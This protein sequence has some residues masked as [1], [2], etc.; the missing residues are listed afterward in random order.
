FNYGTAQGHW[1]EPVDGVRLLS[2]RF[3]PDLPEDFEQMRTQYTHMI[4]C[5]LAY[6][7]FTEWPSDSANDDDEG[8]AR[9]RQWYQTLFREGKLVGRAKP[10]R[11]LQAYTNP[12][13]RVYRMDGK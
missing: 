6:E 5:E 1:E 3:A 11:N 12:E 7:R 9:R 8:V 13:I 4:V 2:L 10:P